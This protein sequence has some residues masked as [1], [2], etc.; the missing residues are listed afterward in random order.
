LTDTTAIEAL[1][2]EGELVED[3]PGEWGKNYWH[4]NGRDL[5]LDQLEA[6]IRQV[7]LSKKKREEFITTMTWWL[8]DLLNHGELAHGEEFSQLLDQFD[9][10]ED[11]Y[12]KIAATGEAFPIERRQLPHE[13]SFW[14]HEF[15][16]SLKAEVAD[17]L[18]QRFA[19]RLKPTSQHIGPEQPDERT[20]TG[21]V[22]L[23]QEA[24]AQRMLGGAKD[25]AAEP[26]ELWDCPCCLGAGKVSK[27]AREQYLEVFS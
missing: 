27:L 5:S 15:L 3:L 22:D 11:S 12:R 4:P 14:D 26:P 8:A 19:D 24:K 23:R 10:Q 17:K 18:L 1:V 25:D 6:L 13:A 7:A 21:R 9:Y 20:I 16:R 2:E